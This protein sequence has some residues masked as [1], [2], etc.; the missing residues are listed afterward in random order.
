MNIKYCRQESTII[1]N[2]I[3]I[4]T[5]YQSF[6]ICLQNTMCSLNKQNILNHGKNFRINK[7]AIY[8]FL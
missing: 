3:K 7:R 8:A 1:L 4:K 2:F 6:Y 5:L